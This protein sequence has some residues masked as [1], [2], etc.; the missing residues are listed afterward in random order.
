MTLRKLF[1]MI[2]D[3]WEAYRPWLPL[4]TAK[5]FLTPAGRPGDV[6]GGGHW[7]VIA[8][9]ALAVLVLVGVRS[10]RPRA[11]SAARR[12]AIHGP[13]LV[14]RRGH[15]RGTP[16]PVRLRTATLSSWHG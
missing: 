13:I 4:R 8:F 11:T 5:F 16:I 1:D 2:P 9:V 10:G 7:A 6:L 3:V 14:L 15:T 12:V